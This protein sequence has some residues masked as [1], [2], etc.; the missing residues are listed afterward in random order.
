MPLIYRP[1][2]PGSDYTVYHSGNFNPDN[3][4]PKD[5]QCGIG[6]QMGDSAHPHPHRLGCGNVSMD[7]SANVSL[8]VTN[9]RL[10]SNSEMTYGWNGINYFNLAG[11]AGA[12]A[13]INDTPTTAWWHILRFNHGAARVLYRSGSSV[14]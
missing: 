4:L 12:A 14:Q 11:T 3:Y 6:Q 9:N 8:S 2:D 1:V 5:C 7:G 13:K 10:N